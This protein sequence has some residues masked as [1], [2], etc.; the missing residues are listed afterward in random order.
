MKWAQLRF[1]CMHGFHSEKN[2]GELRGSVA[3]LIKPYKYLQL[4]TILLTY[5]MCFTENRTY[6]T[7]AIITRSL[8]TFY[9]F[10]EVQIR[11]FQ[12]SFFLKFLPYVRL[13]FKS[14]FKSITGYDGA[15]TV[16]KNWCSLSAI[17]L[18]I[19]L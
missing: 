18:S 11:F 12:G 3:S 13:V 7:C 16:S 5:K 14:S 19:P 2:I 9:P 1:P 15:F 6:R 17:L 10:L 4:W 8:Y